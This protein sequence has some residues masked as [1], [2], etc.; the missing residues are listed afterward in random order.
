MVELSVDRAISDNFDEVLIRSLAERSFARERLFRTANNLITVDAPDGSGKGAIASSI[1][2][3]LSSIYGDSNVLLVSPNGF[4][5]SPQSLEIGK[6]LKNQ[7]SLSP[8]S[9]RH[10]S[11][12]MATTMVN[13]RTV[14]FPALE[15]GKIVVVDSSEIRSLAYILD[16]GSSA[17]IRSTLRWI[18]GGRATFG[19]L[20]GNRILVTVSPDDCLAN[21][22]ARGKRDY[23]DPVDYNEALKRAD[24]YALSILYLKGLKQDSPS[25]WINVENHRIETDDVDAYLNQLVSRKIIPYLYL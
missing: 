23:G 24:C 21:I 17:A 20:A 22:N 2:Q 9:V 11:H 8:S 15:A 10:N 6:K 14:I 1:W 18:R 25:N 4:D 12:F 13:Y 5:Q 3:Q 19:L 16:R 7:P